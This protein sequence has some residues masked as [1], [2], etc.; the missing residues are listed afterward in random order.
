MESKEGSSV[1]TAEP[2][3]NKYTLKEKLKGMGPAF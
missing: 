2:L 1:N 3:Y